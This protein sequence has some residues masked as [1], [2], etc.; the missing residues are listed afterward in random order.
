MG[1]HTAG[2][3]AKNVAS[4]RVAKIVGLDPASPLFTYGNADG[5][6]ANTD[7][8]Y[9]EVIHSNAGRLGFSQP[10][11][12]ASFYPNGGSS[13]PG[14]GWDVSGGCAHARAYEFYIESIHSKEKFYGFECESLA[15]VRRGHCET[16][17]DLVQMAGEPG[18]KR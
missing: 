16:V 3:A 14:C 9:V 12:H 2:I 4:G 10:L 8:E 7:A 1:A 17:G 11:G 18:P 13:Q 6:L 15:N 5:R